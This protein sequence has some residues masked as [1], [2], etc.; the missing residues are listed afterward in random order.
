MGWDTAYP[1][2]IVIIIEKIFEQAILTVTEKV[3]HNPL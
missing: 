1:R 3:I 2:K